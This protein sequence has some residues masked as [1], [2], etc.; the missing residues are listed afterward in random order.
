MT[1][2]KIAEKSAATGHNWIVTEDYAPLN[3]LRLM[4]HTA[5]VRQLE[6]ENN[7]KELRDLFGRARTN[8]AKALEG[9]RLLADKD[10]IWMATRKDAT[11]TFVLLVKERNRK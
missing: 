1:W 2:H 4:P 11:D 10:R 9:V 5:H 7:Y 8:S 3:L 6:R